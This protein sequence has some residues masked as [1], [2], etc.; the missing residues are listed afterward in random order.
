MK[1][2]AHLFLIL[3]AGVLVSACEWTMLDPIG[4][5]DEPQEDTELLEFLARTPLPLMSLEGTTWVFNDFIRTVNLDDR[6]IVIPPE[7]P[8][9]NILVTGAPPLFCP[10]EYAVSFENGKVM[11][12]W[13]VSTLDKKSFYFRRETD[14]SSGAT[15][16]YSLDE[17]D[18]TLNIFEPAITWFEEPLHLYVFN[19]SEI[20][21]LTPFGNWGYD[22]LYLSLG[23]ASS[24][25]LE[26]LRSA[27][28]VG[29]PEFPAFYDE[30]L[31]AVEENIRSAPGMPKDEMGIESWK[32]TFVRYIHDLLGYP[33]L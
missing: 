32:Y 27:P 26:V 25:E 8:L 30:M 22:Y 2:F 5:P 10:E 1:R 33:E 9:G 16:Q 23:A 12:Y 14:I 6:G 19:P 17:K 29:D 24:A 31:A 20:I 18:K 13:K 11:S 15:L 4:D 3:C 28:G 7:K 21:F